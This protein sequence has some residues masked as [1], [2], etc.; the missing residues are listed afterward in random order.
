MRPSSSRAALRDVDDAPRRL[1]AGD[2]AGAAAA[3]EGREG[4]EA[5]VVR[6][7]S[8]HS[9]EGPEAR[10]GG[11]RGARSSGRASTTSARLAFLGTLGNNAPF[12]GL[13]GTVLGIIRAFFDLAAHPGA[14]GAGTVMAGITEALVATAVG[15][16]VALPAVVAFNLFQRCAPARR[17]SAR[18]RSGTRRWPISR[19]GPAEGRSAWRAS[20]DGA[21]DDDLISG[22]NVTPLVDVVLVLLIIFMVTAT[23]IVRASIEVDL[24]RAAH[25]GEATGTILS[26]VAHER[27]TRSGS[28]APGARR[29]SSSPARREAVSK[30]GDARAIISADKGA[31]HGSV[32]RVIDLVR[33]AGVTRFAIHVDKE[34]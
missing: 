17:R 9:A 2:L 13:F 14:S 34:R 19:P 7:A 3:V 1:L 4:L 21:D 12:V 22:I 5:D 28:T 18:P 8:A 31:L 25:G 11:G 33:G 16:F 27:T 32:V 20:A 15:L 10:R 29:R 23:Y 24:P 30:D 6:A 26:V